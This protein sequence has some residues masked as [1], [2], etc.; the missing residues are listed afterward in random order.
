M[1]S[2]TLENA[3]L[4][5][6][7]VQKGILQLP[8]APHAG[9]A[10]LGN[11]SRLAEAFRSSRA[12]VALSSVAWA[13]DFSDAL[14]QPVDRPLPMP[15]GGLPA[16]WAELPGDLSVNGGDI[17]FTKRQ[18]NAF[19]GTELDLQ[20]RRRGIKTLVITGVATNMGVESTARAAYDLGYQL[21]FAEDA[22][23]SVSPEMHA[24]AFQT[25]FPMIGRVRTTEQIIA[26]LK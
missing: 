6:V 2:L 16:D 13:A 17:V 21:V 22:I 20:L 24:F 3:A 8:L 4:L 15:E 19:Y 23:S 25:I 5:V 14:T 12:P 10:V 7:D 1:E 9:T 18:W 11:S 26:A